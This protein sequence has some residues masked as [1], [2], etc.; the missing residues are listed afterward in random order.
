MTEYAEAQTGA[1][2]PR[3]APHVATLVLIA[4]INPLALNVF[5]PSM[6]GM[7]GEFGV[8]YTT[9]Q[10]GLSLFLVVTA[11]IAFIAGPLSDIFG[12]RPVI[13]GGFL[14]FLAGTAISLTAQ[15]VEMFLA[16]RI[17]QTGSAVG[18]ALSRAIV[19]DLF[20]RNKAASMI[21]YVT[22]GMSIAPMLGP[23]IGGL[24]DDIYG[25]RAGFLLLAAVGS[26]AVLVALTALPETNH[27]RGRPLREQIHD[28]RE[29]LSSGD[30]WIF[31]FT[32]SLAACVFFGFLGGGPVIASNYLGM[33][34]AAYGLWFAACAGGYL[35]GNFISGRFS[36]RV[37]VARMIS[38]G[39]ALSVVGG[40]L[41]LI[42]LAA[43]IREPIALFGPTFV[44]GIGNGMTLPNAISAAVSVRP[45]AA[46]AASGLM[47]SMQLG[48]GA[49]ASVICGMAAGNGEDYIGFGTALAVISI[50]ALLVA[51]RASVLARRH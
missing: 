46:G 10:L 32:G 8:P 26:L 4:A 15:S 3:R 6:P 1:A 24:L 50:A 30:Y 33:S 49:G 14:L 20:S 38:T 48:L 35:V 18:I 39:A 7:A 31:V 19:R 11:V 44:I 36:E 47:G 29:L 43:G 2:A 41:P 13:L 37:G 25:W 5:I 28:Y 27:G 45:T 21:G 40:T 42:L 34:S 9:I 17:V 16:G 12:R 51:F 22:M 23:A